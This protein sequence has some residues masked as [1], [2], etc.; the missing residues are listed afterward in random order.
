MVMFSRIRLPVKGR[1]GFLF[2]RVPSCQSSANADLVLSL[3]E[4]RPDHRHS[5]TYSVVRGNGLLPR[6]S[7]GD[8]AWG[9]PC[10]YSTLT[11]TF[12]NGLSLSGRSP[13]SV[14]LGTGRQETRLAYDFASIV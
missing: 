8:Q 2:G 7:L 14:E 13:V 9:K 10:R 5:E 4:L 6:G 1:W 12:L 3:L 11:P